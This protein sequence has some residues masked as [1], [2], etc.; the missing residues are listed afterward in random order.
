MQNSSRSNCQ[1]SPTKFVFR[2]FLPAV[3]LWAMLGSF[4]QA[5]AQANVVRGKIIEQRNSAGQ[6]HVYIPTR[7][8]PNVDVLV[9]C[10]GTIEKANAFET[11]KV[12]LERWIKL[13]EQTGIVLIAPAFDVRNYASGKNVPGGAAWGYRALDG[14]NTTPD[15][16]IHQILDQLKNVAPKY[17]G[18]FYL[19]GH[20]AGAQ[21]AN[22][23]LVV[24]PTRLNGVILSAPAITGSL[25][26]KLL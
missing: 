18:K 1:F 26:Q 10:H 21:F 9:I 24:H 14:R 5:Y 15:K 11:S 13:S 19:Y 2:F 7:V 12:F 6:F 25:S 3:C 8:V 20:S 16:F 22:H 4:Q 23:Y 17:D